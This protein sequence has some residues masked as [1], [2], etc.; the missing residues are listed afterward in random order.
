LRNTLYGGISGLVSR[1]A[2]AN[3]EIISKKMLVASGMLVLPAVGF[4][5]NLAFFNFYRIRF[6]FC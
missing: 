5:L 2:E 3:L 6:L 1:T 4:R